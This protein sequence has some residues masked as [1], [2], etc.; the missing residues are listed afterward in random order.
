MGFL[1]L[2]CGSD[3]KGRGAHSG[4][5]EGQE[6]CGRK[7]KKGKQERRAGKNRKGQNEKIQVQSRVSRAGQNKDLL[8][9][10]LLVERPFDSDAEAS[11]A[12][13]ESEDT[14]SKVEAEVAQA[15][16]SDESSG[17]TEVEAEEGDDEAGAEEEVAGVDEEVSGEPPVS[18]VPVDVL[19]MMNEEA[20]MEEEVFSITHFG[21][22]EDVFLV[23]YQSYEI[24][25]DAPGAC[26]QLMGKQFQDVRIE[27]NTDVFPVI[28]GVDS[29]CE[30]G[31]YHLINNS[32][33][34]IWDDYDMEPS[35]Y[36]SSSDCQKLPL[37]E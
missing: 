7:G 15:N 32:I 22:E 28:C 16:E 27:D 20:M 37:S 3:R 8:N 30:P 29:V 24:V 36:N 35:E 25:L 18:D 33:P 26:V 10:D 17:A 5:K 13:A 19:K 31:N 11:G 4:C 23:Q 14:G 9:K 21:K 6:D 1:M 2:S 34:L 12:A